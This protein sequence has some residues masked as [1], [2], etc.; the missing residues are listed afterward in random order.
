[1]AMLS[2][3]PMSRAEDAS[4]RTH[5]K[6]ALRV[7]QSCLRAGKH[8]KK[9]QPSLLLHS[10][11]C[12]NRT[13]LCFNIESTRVVLPWSTWAMMAMLRMSSRTEDRYGSAA[14]DELGAGGAVRRNSQVSM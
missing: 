8:I 1:M 13:L 9:V 10:A 6:R 2:Y 7:I 12:V 4:F 5:T 14:P 3:I 11:C